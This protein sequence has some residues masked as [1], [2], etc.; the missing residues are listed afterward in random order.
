M[1][2]P[3]R[4][5]ATSQ[6]TLFIVCLGLL[7]LVGLYLALRY[8]P[9]GRQSPAVSEHDLDTTGQQTSSLR[10]E[11]VPAAGSQPTTPTREEQ[12]MSEDNTAG[13]EM[14]SCPAM[15]DEL[16]SFFSY[17]DE[18]PYI[19]EFQFK[20]GIFPHFREILKKLF[21][22][23]P[24]VR[25]ASNDLF[26][27]LKNVAYFY[28]ALGA[29]DIF[30]AK[31]YL[32]NDEGRLEHDLDIFYRWLQ[33]DSCRQQQALNLS[34]PLPALYEYAAYF[35][36]S[37]GGKS[38]LFRRTEHTGLVVEYYC[39]LLVDLADKE[40]L[41]R[42]GID[43]VPIIDNISERMQRNT[44]LQNRAEYLDTLRKLRIRYTGKIKPAGTAGGKS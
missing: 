22:A 31:N 14:D 41:N 13:A 18:Q 27:Q 26:G 36:T 32:A 10:P 12:D 25:I 28:R 6:R 3:S 16:S 43:L 15:A 39:I 8:F 33:Q 7:L 23:P 29:K 5:I 35:L 44:S 24:T 34:L 38:Y 19:Q 40:G 20:D 42:Y 37:A 30:L 1:P 9:S 17:L 11:T 4:K 21:N 2:K